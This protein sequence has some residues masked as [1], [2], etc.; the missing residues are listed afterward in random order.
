LR[1]LY[2]K[3]RDQKVEGDEDI[4]NTLNKHAYM[5]PAETIPVGNSKELLCG[6]G[7]SGEYLYAARLLPSHAVVCGG[8]GFR[9]VRVVSRETKMASRDSLLFHTTSHCGNLEQFTIL[10]LQ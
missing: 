3:K 1:S 6:D 10:S 4:L 9:E 7:A 8:S 2:S 5:C